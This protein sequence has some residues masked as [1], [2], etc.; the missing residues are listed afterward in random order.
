MRGISCL[1]ALLVS[2]CATASQIVETRDV[3]AYADARKDQD[4]DGAYVTIPDT[5]HYLDH[6]V[7]VT[8]RSPTTNEPK[9][10]HTNYTEIV[11]RY[12][13]GTPHAV[14]VEVSAFA[15]GSIVVAEIDLRLTVRMECSQQ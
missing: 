9:S 7:E 8:R 2:F 10:L 15:W 1:I 13:D 11:H 6:D 3:K 14:Q 12:P 4:Y 5:C